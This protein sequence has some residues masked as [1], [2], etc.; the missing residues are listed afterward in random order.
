MRKK[1]LMGACLAMLSIASCFAF[2]S[3]RWKGGVKY[4]LNE[5]GESYY[6]AGCVSNLGEAVILSTYNGLPVTHIGHEAFLNCENLTSVTIGENITTIDSW[7]FVNCGTLTNI[8]VDENNKIYQVI[9]GDLYTKDMMLVTCV[10]GRKDADFVVFDGVTGIGACAF[11]MNS[12]LVSVTLPDSVTFINDYAFDFCDNLASVVMGDG[13]TT[14]GGGAFYNCDGLTSVEIGASVTTIGGGAFE[15][16]A[17]LASVV[18]PDSVTMIADSVFEYCYSLTSVEIGA[19]VTTIGDYAFRNCRSLT[20]MEIP[21]SVT[22]IGF[23]AFENCTSLTSVYITDIAAWC[24]ISFDWYES[25]PLYHAS[26]L[27]LNNELITNLV[28]PDTVTTIGAYAFYNYTSLT[29]V[30]IPDSVTKI[31]ERAF[32]YCKDLTNVVIGENV[33]SIGWGAFCYCDG[34]TSCIFKAPNGWQRRKDSITDYVYPL[35]D[36]DVSDPSVAA[37]KI[38]EFYHGIGLLG[39]VTLMYEWHK[40][41]TV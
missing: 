33:S 2:S 19:N 31:C 1:I 17:S 21:A 24:N 9:D 13:V 41:S 28:I 22:T 36:V 11:A 16:C 6:V 5:D 23:D 10:A 15:D 7:A 40:M 26:N 3:C 8:S 34:L 27:Y 14:I 29:S 20:N 12:N 25:N 37:E 35:E 30:E 4:V 32:A 38:R 39:E 18:I